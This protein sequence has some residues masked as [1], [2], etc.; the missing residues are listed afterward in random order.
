M[1]P[2][3]PRAPQA[4]RATHTPRPRRGAIAA[5]TLALGLVTACAS[6]AGT[7]ETGVGSG[8]DEAA[9]PQAEDM[10]LT[11]YGPVRGTVADDHRTF[12]GIPYAAPPV[13]ELRWSPPAPPE[14]WSEPFDA[15]APGSACP[16][17]ANRPASVPSDSEDC[18]YLNVTTPVSEPDPDQPRPVMVWLHGNDFNGSA[19]EVY[20]A[21]R[22]AAQ[23]DAVVVTVNYRIGALG[24]LAHP[25]LDGDST[26]E[27]S[28]NHGLQDQQAALEWV[29]RNA[30]AFG[31]DADNVTLFGESAGATAVCAQMAAPSSADLFDRAIV[32]SGLC[33]NPHGELTDSS[34]RARETAEEQGRAVAEALGCAG[35]E[36]NDAGEDS[37]EN[38]GER[39]RED[40]GDDSREDTGADADDDAAVSDCLREATVAEI[41]EASENGAGVGPVVGDGFLPVSPAEAFAEGSTAPVPLMVGITR[42]EYRLHA[43]G[44]ELMN[45]GPLTEEDVEGHFE[46]LFP[47]D[48]EAIADLYPTGDGE[49]V[50]ALSAALTDHLFAA[51]ARSIA[52]AHAELAPVHFFEFAD[53]PAL[54]FEGVEQPSY[55]PGAF[56]SAELPYLFDTGYSAELSAEQAEL[57][58]RMIGYWANFARTGDPNGADLPE[59]APFTETDPAVQGLVS[60]ED[61]I[62][63]VDFDENHHTRFWAER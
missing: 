4:L 38:E 44:M 21:R 11:E 19:G 46:A 35:N 15:T 63:P 42:D 26:Q 52:G 7:S 8:A 58:D 22:L 57:A 14:S 32:Q 16:Q 20:G 34:P 12:Q 51:S 23:G 43:W 60:G 28:G 27:M 10:V 59:W 41:A 6:P 30:G 50:H 24:F 37:R 47:E 61:G 29:R 39:S 13:G 62:G 56:H 49:P 53:D 5:L 36:G 2:H 31:G 54:W 55:E 17:E 1:A 48:S 40:E 25:A 9:K 33:A 45:G 18:L 3:A